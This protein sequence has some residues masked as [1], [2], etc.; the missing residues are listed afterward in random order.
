M[1]DIAL[2]IL[3]KIGYFFVDEKTR[4]MGLGRVLLNTAIEWI[5]SNRNYQLCN[6]LSKQIE[7]PEYQYIRL[8]TLRGVMED[9][10]KI[11]ERY[12]FVI[13]EESQNEYF[14]LVYMRLKI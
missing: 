1:S 3:Q 2:L 13:Y 4:G 6:P 5:R 8:I 12:G 11:Y 10:I 9:A 14:L 7:C